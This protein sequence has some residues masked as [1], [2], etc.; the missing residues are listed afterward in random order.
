MGALV[1]VACG[2]LAWMASWV[3]LSYEALPPARV[4]V[5]MRAFEHVAKR[6]LARLSSSSAC[7]LLGGWRPVCVVA[8]ELRVRMDKAGGAFSQQECIVLLVVACMAACVGTGVIMWSPVGCVASIPVLV[9]AF[10]IRAAQVQRAR[11]RRIIEQMPDVFRTLATA[12]GAGHTLMQAIDYVGLHEGGPA[13][14][15]FAHASLRLRCGMSAE[16][17][18]GK[19]AAELDAPGAGLMVCALSISQRTGCPLKELFQRSAVLVEQ[20]GEF[21]RTLAVK[22]AQVRL[23]VR[24]VCVLPVAMVVLLSLISPDF[25]EGLGTPAGIGCLA[26]G[27]LMDCVALLAIRSMLKGVLR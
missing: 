14:E 2:G 7:A 19:L 1:C 3:L 5:R 16:E 11:E 18:L 9:C 8:E 23:S 13:A 15:A 17:A 21:E 12:L 4:G 24:I 25:R 27:V 26:V 22:T 20:Q 10:P 6:V